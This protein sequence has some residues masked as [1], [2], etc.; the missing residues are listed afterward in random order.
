MISLIQTKM[1][2]FSRLQ[3]WTCNIKNFGFHFSFQSHPRTF[4]LRGRLWSRTNFL[5]ISIK[6]E[7]LRRSKNNVSK[8]LIGPSSF[9][10]PWPFHKQAL[11]KVD[12]ILAKI[13]T[14][15]S[16]SV[17]GWPFKLV[18]GGGVIIVEK[19]NFAQSNQAKIEICTPKSYKQ[20]V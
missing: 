11:K 6:F 12:K 13:G 18:E 10:E 19:E 1:H 17:R 3:K 16:A 15:R 14:Y 4:L 2:D 7:T 5:K 8:F 9:C 20:N